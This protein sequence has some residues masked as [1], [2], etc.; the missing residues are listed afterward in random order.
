M[1]TYLPDSKK[2]TEVPS[3][4]S[5]KQP[6]PE[7]QLDRVFTALSDR[8]RRALVR[9]LAQGPAMV[10][11]LAQPFAMS[12]IAVSKHLRVLQDAK[13]VEREIDGRIHRCSLKPGPLAEAN[14]WL[15]QYQPF[16]VG[17]L[18]SLANH[19]KAAGA[20]RGKLKGVKP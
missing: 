5:K 4:Q 14:V 3:S 17:S 8:T 13:L 10:S 11:E 9:R 18:A 1:V 6:V 19:A 20:L 7:E 2:E 15:Q 12:R 16:W